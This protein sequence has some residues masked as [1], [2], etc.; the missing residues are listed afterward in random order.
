MFLD[1]TYNGLNL[2]AQN[3]DHGF[4]AVAFQGHILTDKGLMTDRKKVK[5]IVN[6][7]LSKAPKDVL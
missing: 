3:V 6:M 2:S 7:P 1:V 4:M 5:A